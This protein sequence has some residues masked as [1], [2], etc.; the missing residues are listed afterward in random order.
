MNTFLA[1]GNLIRQRDRL[2]SRLKSKSNN[3]LLVVASV[4]SVHKNAAKEEELSSS[5]DSHEKR[6]R[7]FFPFQTY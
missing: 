1:D 6:K 7:F 2:M 3:I 4:H 5:F